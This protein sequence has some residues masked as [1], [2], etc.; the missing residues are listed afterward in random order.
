MAL[1]VDRGRRFSG[2]LSRELA[3]LARARG[4]LNSSTQ[5]QVVAPRKLRRGPGDTPRCR[6]GI[7][8]HAPGDAFEPQVLQQDESPA[9]FPLK[10]QAITCIVCWMQIMKLSE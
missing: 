4:R 2:R 1:V 3:R 10:L 7:L 6:V 8:G 9:V 5:Q